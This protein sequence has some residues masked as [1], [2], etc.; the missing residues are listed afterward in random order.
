MFFSALDFSISR[1]RS[2]TTYHTD[3]QGTT[4]RSNVIPGLR[5]PVPRIPITGGDVTKRLLQLSA[6]VGIKAAPGLPQWQVG[7]V[8]DAPK[9]T[10]APEN[11]E[12]H[13]G[14][15]INSTIKLDAG[16]ATADHADQL[17]VIT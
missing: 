6:R 4:S 11:G 8:N 12:W 14:A 10:Y 15:G 16:T 3:A 9:I 13:V 17:F 7:I 5:A 2:K 1:H